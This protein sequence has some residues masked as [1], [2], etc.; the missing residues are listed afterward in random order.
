M[1]VFHKIG[2]ASGS[3]CQTLLGVILGSVAAVTL[4]F[5]IV[6]LI[7]TC[8]NLRVLPGHNKRKGGKKGSTGRKEVAKNRWKEATLKGK[9]KSK[10]G[11]SK[12]KSKVT[13]TYRISRFI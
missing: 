10:L 7:L 1:C 9:L 12:N 3:Q 6:A 11:K 5:N 4:T 2:F 8:M 13:G